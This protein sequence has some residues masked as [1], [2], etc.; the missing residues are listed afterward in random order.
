VGKITPAGTVSEYMIPTANSNSSG[1]TVGPDGNLWFTEFNTNKVGRITP[2]GAV[3]EF[4]IPTS[5]SAPEAITAGP[6]GNLWF[7][8]VGANKVGRITSGALAGSATVNVVAAAADHYAV[9]TSAANPDIAG[10]AFDVTVVA[11]DPYG[12]TD[13]GYTGTVHFSSAD[14]YGAGL[15]AD[16]TFTAA[17][18]GVHTFAAGATLYTASTTALDYSNG[19][20]DPSNLTANGNTT[21][22][23]SPPVLRLTDGGGGEASSAWYNRPGGAGAF[24]TT[25][26]LQDR[27][28]AG[29]ADGVCFVLQAD[30]RGQ[31][32]L[33]LGGGG[34][35]YAGIANSIA[36]KFDLYTHG[37]HTPSTGLFTGGQSPDSDPSKDVPLT[38]INLGSDDPLQV[39]LTYDGTGT[40]TETVTDTVTQAMFT[41]S[42]ALNLAQVLGSG[43]AYA[44]FTGGTGAET[45]VQ[46]IVNWTGSF[47]VNTWNVTASDTQSGI[48]GAAYVNV[49]AAPAV[50]LAVV[51]PASATSGVAFDVTVIAVDPYGNTDTNYQGT[52]TF[53][54]SDP[55]PGVLLPPDY[56]FQASDQGMVTFAG[57]VTLITPGDQTLTATDTVSGITGTATVTVTSGP[58]PGMGGFGGKSAVSQ[59]PPSANV[60]TGTASRSAV[61]AD[62]ESYPVRTES[63]A[64]TAHRAVLIDHVW[65]DLADPLFTGPWLDG[66]V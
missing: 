63:V 50:A 32:A 9:V 64:A 31:A 66:L 34:E 59:Q 48:T 43:V 10:T 46:D 1:I 44:G 19:F 53:S 30:P 42:Y 26:T 54:T 62:Q 17:D 14:P 57:G 47:H 55:D 11:T 8:E 20:G 37:F 3:T 18:Q 60:A 27:P 6:D 61:S 49:Q 15:P 36:I 7:A 38:G 13:T 45:A 12:N 35:G 22:P 2:T 24:T 40:L 16:Y 28:V 58:A 52:V 39:T 33:G 5:G 56:T 4:S 23:G 51:A 41:H 29:A 25:F 65:S 21:F